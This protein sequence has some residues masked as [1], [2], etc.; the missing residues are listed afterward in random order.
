MINKREASPNDWSKIFTNAKAT[1]TILEI[2]GSPQR[3]DLN[4]E[5]VYE[6]QKFGCLFSTNT[7]AHSTDG[8]NTMDLAI[9][10]ARR[11][12]LNKEQVINT[13]SLNQLLKV[14][15]NK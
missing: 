2:N 15:K 1:N 7:D 6:A 9:G 4:G 10:Q 8:L 12:Q 14:I 5:L 3:L 13:Y 11:G